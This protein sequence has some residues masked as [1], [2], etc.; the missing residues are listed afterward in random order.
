MMLSVVR[1]VCINLLGC[2]PFVVEGGLALHFEIHCSPLGVLYAG[3]VLRTWLRHCVVN[4]LLPLFI[5]DVPLR[6]G[7]MLVN[8][9]IHS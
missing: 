6:F 4:L 3:Q 9:W 7:P 2:H 8:L 5:L 1:V